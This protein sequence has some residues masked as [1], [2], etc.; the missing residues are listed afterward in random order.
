[1]VR[2]CLALDPLVRPQSVFAMQKVLTTV[3]PAASAARK[4]AADQAP[5]G[6][7]GLFGKLGAITRGKSGQT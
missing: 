6:L 2:A 7:R 3:L 5:G 1:M 4:Q